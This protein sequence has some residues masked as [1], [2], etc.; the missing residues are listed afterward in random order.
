M[1][2]ALNENGHGAYAQGSCPVLESILSEE[3]KRIRN[4]LEFNPELAPSPNRSALVCRPIAW[5]QIATG[6]N[7]D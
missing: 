7:C 6:S 1:C 3:L 4:S 5:D 2:V